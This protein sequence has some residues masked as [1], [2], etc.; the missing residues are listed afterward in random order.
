MQAEALE[1][2][3]GLQTPK[4]HLFHKNGVNRG[5]PSEPSCLTE[6]NQP[7]HREES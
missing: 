4:L 7:G 5:L 3:L 6:Q 2:H 1:T